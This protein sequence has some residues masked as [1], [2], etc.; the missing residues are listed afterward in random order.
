M[1][2][3]CT[4]TVIIE[5]LAI[6]I[7]MNNSLGLLPLEIQT[8]G[9]R[10]LQTSPISGLCYLGFHISSS[11]ACPAVLRYVLP[12][13]PGSINKLRAL[14]PKDEY[15]CALTN[16]HRVSKKTCVLEPRQE[17]RPHSPL[18]KL[19]SIITVQLLLVSELKVRKTAN[20]P[21]STLDFM[22]M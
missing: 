10:Y 20:R 19:C 4:T 22:Q 12:S 3:C 13:A 5:A 2:G 17:S 15:V 21:L 6:P 18:R 1:R 8:V 16:G 11:A 7:R 9:V 14:G